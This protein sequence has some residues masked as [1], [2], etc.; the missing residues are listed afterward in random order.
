MAEKK[1]KYLTYKGKPLVRQGNTIYYG[2]MSDDY[3]IMMQINSSKEFGDLDLASKV[4][5]QLVNTDPDASIKEKIVKTSE[6]KGLYAAMDIA[7]IW[8]TRALNP[9]DE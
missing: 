4:S 3:I 6:K 8:L 2:N 1:Q 7:E 5:I 9:K